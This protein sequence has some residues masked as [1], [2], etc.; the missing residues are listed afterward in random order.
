M[1]ARILTVGMDWRGAER[2]RCRPSRFR[3]GLPRCSLDIAGGRGAHH[4]IPREARSRIAPAPCFPPHGRAWD[5]PPFEGGGVVVVV[6][7]VRPLHNTLRRTRGPG[8]WDSTIVSSNVTGNSAWDEDQNRPVSH[9]PR[10]GVHHG[11]GD[12]TRARRESQ[13]HSTQEPGWVVSGGPPK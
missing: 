5:W 2:A 7:G 6:V 4:D 12:P 8:A 10:P 13:H 3:S 11:L 9:G 1:E